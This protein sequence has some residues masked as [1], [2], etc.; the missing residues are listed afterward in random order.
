M[1]APDKSN[2]MFR[3]PRLTRTRIALAVTVAALADGLQFIFGPVPFVD[4]VIDVVAFGLTAW[5]IGFHMLLLPTFAVEF[6]PVVDMLP[7]WTACV[8]AV[9][10][11]RKRGQNAVPP[12]QPEDRRE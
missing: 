5:A 1:N 9:I 12:P 2:Q 3:A 7:T 4:Q 8:I 10:A 6:I 11:L